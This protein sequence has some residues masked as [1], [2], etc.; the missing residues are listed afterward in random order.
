MTADPTGANPHVARYLKDK[1]A[2]EFRR[3]VIL[4]F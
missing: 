1:A 3:F 2:D 4:F